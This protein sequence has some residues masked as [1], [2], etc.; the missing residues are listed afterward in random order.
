MNQ[1]GIANVYALKGGFQVPSQVIAVPVG[2]DPCEGLGLAPPVRTRNRGGGPY[3]PP[4]VMSN[5]R[6]TGW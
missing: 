2:G 1:K 6:P 5:V 3:A 4:L